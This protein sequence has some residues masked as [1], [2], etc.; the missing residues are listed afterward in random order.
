MLDGLIR[1]SVTNRL[2][3]GVG[4][5]AFLIWG[6]YVASRMPVD[7]LPDVSSPTVTVLVEA[8]GMAPT[9]LEALFSSDDPTAIA[10]A[11]HWRA[12]RN[13]YL[14]WGRDTLGFGLYLFATAS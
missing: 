8:H 2:V 14:S 4:A 11:S 13:A 5:V 10:D 1:W 9:D 7:V 12:W 3:V 6:G